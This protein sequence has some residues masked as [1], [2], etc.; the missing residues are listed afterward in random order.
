MFPIICPPV[1][2]PAGFLLPYLGGMAVHQKA[3]DY[4]WQARLYVV[5]QMAC[6]AVLAYNSGPWRQHPIALV[7]LVAGMLLGGWAIVGMAQGSKLSVMP[8]P[9]AGSRLVTTGL[10]RYLRHPMYTA[11]LLACLGMALSHSGWLAWAAWGLLLLVLCR[12]LLLEEQLL[13]Q[14]FTD[15][16]DYQQRS[17]RLIPLLW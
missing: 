3:V 12:K 11:V 1:P 7:L 2:A 6:I 13:R 5:L 8:Q 9:K 10:Y 4:R 14:K 17:W 15:Y 16:A